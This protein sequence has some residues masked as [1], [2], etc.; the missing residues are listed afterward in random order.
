MPS[1]PRQRAC[2]G[3]H[4][5]P[6]SASATPLPAKGQASPISVPENTFGLGQPS[7]DSHGTWFAAPG[8]I[9]LLRSGKL[10]KVADVPEMLFPAPTP[11][12][13]AEALPPKPATSA[14]IQMPVPKG[15]YLHIA[16]ACA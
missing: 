5:R 3:S 8:Q 2:P 9:W 15:P 16:G 4:P 13:G 7:S 14:A 6:T 12:P 10:T 1:P 11:P